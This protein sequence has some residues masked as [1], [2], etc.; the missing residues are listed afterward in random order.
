MTINSWHAD[1]PLCTSN[2]IAKAGV[3]PQG[4]L[5]ALHSMIQPPAAK[6]LH[7]H[8]PTSVH[9][10]GPVHMG[11]K[12]T[13]LEDLYLLSTPLL[14]DQWESSLLEARVLDIFVEVLIGLCNSFDIGIGA[15]Y[16]SESFFPSNHYCPE[17]VHEFI[18]A[19]YCKE[20]ELGRVSLP[21]KHT[22]CLYIFG[23]HL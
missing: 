22:N 14:A 3:L 13:C 15:L 5:C 2:K 17:E 18:I 7:A 4:S 20:I 10:V 23:L 19:K 9:C 1:K 6:A 21:N 12:P 11:H 8:M 16:L